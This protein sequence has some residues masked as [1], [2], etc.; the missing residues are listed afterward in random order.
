MAVES[1]FEMLRT[2]AQGAGAPVGSAVA[3]HALASS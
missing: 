2:A 3:S 1:E